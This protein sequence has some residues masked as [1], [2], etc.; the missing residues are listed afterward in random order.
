MA[1]IPEICVWCD[2]GGGGCKKEREWEKEKEKEG[3]RDRERLK[4]RNSTEHPH[5]DV[6]YKWNMF[7]T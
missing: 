6:F 5:G 4:D 3:E 2:V 1:I 7:L